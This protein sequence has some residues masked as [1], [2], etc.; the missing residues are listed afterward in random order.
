MKELQTPK[1]LLASLWRELSY[2]HHCITKEVKDLYTKHNPY[3]TKPNMN[4]IV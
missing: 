3:R 2:S 4:E 1:N